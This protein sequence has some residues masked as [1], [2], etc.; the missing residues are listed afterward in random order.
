[1]IH[2]KHVAYSIWGHYWLPSWSTVFRSHLTSNMKNFWWGIVLKLFHAEIVLRRG[3]QVH[4]Y[5]NVLSEWAFSFQRILDFS[6]CKDREFA[7][8]SSLDN[9]VSRGVENVLG[10]CKPLCLETSVLSLA[11]AWATVPVSALLSYMLMW[12]K[13]IFQ[14]SY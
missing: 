5:L 9:F 12:K 10:S 14:N 1:M 8:W 6:P 11:H 2:I 7:A 3:R 13:Y 4:I